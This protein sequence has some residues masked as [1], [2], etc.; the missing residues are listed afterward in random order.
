MMSFLLSQ[1]LHHNQKAQGEQV[2]GLSYVT[3]SRFLRREPQPNVVGRPLASLVAKRR[4]QEL[5]N[6]VFGCL[7]LVR[8]EC[9]EHGAA[10]GL[11][12]PGHSGRQWR[13][14]RDEGDV[15]DDEALR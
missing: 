6:L 4:P 9:V 5:D 12:P 3:S 2:S 1:T 10:E 13:R 15:I 8:R 11:E 7:S 14:T